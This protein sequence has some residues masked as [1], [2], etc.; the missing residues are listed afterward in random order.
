MKQKCPKCN[1]VYDFE[2][3]QKGQMFA[4]LECGEDFVING[5]NS[6]HSELSVVSEK[7]KNRF[8]LLI[9]IAG[10]VVLITILLLLL[11]GNGCGKKRSGSA[12]ETDDRNQEIIQSIKSGDLEQVSRLLQHK[13]LQPDEWEFLF[14][15]VNSGK[16]DMI[17]TVLSAGVSVNSVNA[18]GENALFAAARNRDFAAFKLLVEKG[19]NSDMSVNFGARTIWSVAAENGATEII[20][21]L[22][23]A[24]K[25]ISEPASG[26]K[27]IFRAL[28]NGHWECVKLLLDNYNV[29]ETDNSG[30]TILHL[31][32]QKKNVEMVQTLLKR[33]AN[34]NLTNNEGENALFVAIKSSNSNLIRLFDLDKFNL[35][36]TSNDGTSLP[37]LCVKRNN[38]EMLRQVLNTVNIN[39]A[40]SKGKTALYYACENNNIIAIDVL[41]GMNAR[42]NADSLMNSPLYIAVKTD[43]TNA[44][45]MLKSKGANFTPAAVDDNGNNLL[46]LT[47]ESGNTDIFKLLPLSEFDL[48]KTNNKKQTAYAIAAEKRNAV[49]PLLLDLMDNRLYAE[50]ERQVKA[51]TSEGSFTSQIRLLEELQEKMKTYRK[52]TAYIEKEKGEVRKKIRYAATEKVR[53]AINSAKRDKYY[54]SAIKTLE[55]AIANNAEASNLD[56]AKSYLEKL[57]RDLARDQEKREALEKKKNAIRRMSSSALSAE[58]TSFINRWLTDMRLERSTSHYWEYPV[59]ASTLFNVKSWEIIGASDGEWSHFYETVVVSIVS[60]N[61][62]GTPIHKNWKVTLQRNDDMNWKITNLA[63]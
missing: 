8:P 29:D 13:T 61:K 23:V 36:E 5:E 2:T 24:K 43:N 32:L 38:N 25:V 53:N 33:G 48:F 46:M 7:K 19:A 12:G 22:T 49:A 55:N 58:I 37:I 20:E 9:T 27:L 59:L 21:Y 6:F 16:A 4:C 60:T 57:R 42:C 35:T 18:D 17:L 28:Q 41:L 31:A 47:A 3:S 62:G 52:I 15:A 45:R 54:Q 39:I 63:E 44:V 34:A 40:D 50:V 1:Q 30:N 14:A 51:I 26:D 11:S 10:A 56:E